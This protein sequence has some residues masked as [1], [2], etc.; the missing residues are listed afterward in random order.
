M[1]GNSRPAGCEYRD[2]RCNQVGVFSNIGHGNRSVETRGQAG[3][4]K[5]ELKGSQDSMTKQQ[6]E[7]FELSPPAWELDSQNDWVAARIVFS[8]PPFGPYDY[9]VPDWALPKLQPGMRVRVPL[10]A[11]NRRMTGYCIE[12]VRG[13]GQERIDPGK[14]KELLELIDEQPLLTA[15]LLDLARWIS[16]YYVAYLGPTLDAVVP[17][18][19][20]E[21]AGT[22]EVLFLT[23]TRDAS[24]RA[25][26][27]L[28]ATQQRIVD[29]LDRA[30][31]PLTISELAESAAC[32]PGPINLLRKK[33]VVVSQAMRI[34]QREHHLAPES[35]EGTFIP[36]ADQVRV[37]EQ[38]DAALNAMR[39]ETFLVHG[40]TGS[41]KTEVYIRAIERVISFGRQAIV[42]VPEISLTPQTRRRFRARFERVAVLHSHMTAAER[43]WHWKEIAAGHI[44][45]VIGARSAIFAPL[46]H[47]G[48][49]VIDEEHDAS[50]K[51]DKNPRYHARDVALWRARRGNLPVLLGSATPALESWYRARPQAV[52]IAGAGRTQAADAQAQFRPPALPESIASDSDDAPPA[53]A[54]S[55]LEVAPRDCES[56][57]PIRYSLA[58]LPSR[59]LDRPLPDV[60]TIDLRTEFKNRT[61]RGAVS[62]QLQAA[63]RNA[64]Q[65]GG[66]VIL[67]LNRRGFSTSIQCPACGEVVYCPDCSIPMTH[68]REGEKII[69]HYCDHTDLVP[70]NCPNPDCRFTDIRFTG[71]GTQKLELEVKARFPDVP[72][73]R[74]DTDTMQKQGAH[75]KA[76][77]AFRK[78]ETRILL[79]TQMIAKGLDFPNVTLVGVINADTALHFPDFRAAERTFQL[80]TQVAGRSGRG[81]KGGRVLV[82]TFSPE[83]P[84]IIAATQHD[85]EAFA[86]IEILQREEHGYPPFARLAR[87]I[88]R[89]ESELRVEQFADSLVRSIETES[90]RRELVL[91][92]AGPAPC[93][94]EKLRGKYRYHCLLSLPQLADDP[95]DHELQEMLMGIQQGKE[96]PEDIQ[97]VIDIDPLDLL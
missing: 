55:K 13:G 57:R 4:G 30:G 41:G 87:L 24:V 39:H 64:L 23:V 63:M 26:N 29:T 38:I 32:T 27:R 15:E 90:K 17:A 18:G 88:I 94:V 1:S 81:D 45:V 37:L 79:G 61:S 53:A 14:L 59:V 82:Q 92:V 50:F 84:A 69:C 8:S 6:Q 67:L 7:L 36:N 40:I 56:P 42:L 89:G 10:G 86:R 44:Q 76:L 96:T 16:K 49:I 20:R 47:L 72:C 52:G 22:R 51:Q 21:K 60:A 33:G 2:N 73:A 46:P 74:M 97:W 48:L 25:A 80:V 66:Q 65:D 43:A 31:Q 5:H 85:Y 68:H 62:R 78:Q 28:T 19:V 95:G 83:H 58:Q 93:P 11:G 54:D 77:D 12:L 91:D 75:E 3:F 9:R 35:S 71:F 70:L 34:W